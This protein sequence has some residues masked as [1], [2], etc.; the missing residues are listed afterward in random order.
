MCVQRPHQAIAWEGHPKSLPLTHKSREDP[1]LPAELCLVAEP[2][3]HTPPS[4]MWPH[5]SQPQIPALHRWHMCHMQMHFRRFM[6]D[7]HTPCPAGPAPRAS[8]IAGEPLPGTPW[9]RFFFGGDFIYALWFHRWPSSLP[10]MCWPS[11]CDMVLSH[12]R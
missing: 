9:P 4:W 12:N 10:T 2:S 8:D 6:G 7:G 5:H 1:V 3:V 11:L